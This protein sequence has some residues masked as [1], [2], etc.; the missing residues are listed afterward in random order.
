MRKASLVIPVLGLLL[1][2]GRQDYTSTKL[3]RSQDLAPD[4]KENEV[5]TA[6]EVCPVSISGRSTLHLFPM[7]RC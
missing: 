6:A 3:N 4:I 2:L 7:Q 1:S 5:L